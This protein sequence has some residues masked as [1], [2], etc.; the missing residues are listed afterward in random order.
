[1]CSFFQCREGLHRLTVIGCWLTFESSVVVDIRVEK[2]Q[3]KLQKIKYLA[4]YLYF[5]EPEAQNQYSCPF[6][7][8]FHTMK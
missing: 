3:K 7:A 4:N 2:M 8:I 1:M 5:T 6:R